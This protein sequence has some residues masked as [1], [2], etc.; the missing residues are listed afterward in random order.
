MSS[1]DPWISKSKDVSNE[2]NRSSFTDTPKT[3]PEPA[4]APRSCKLD[5]YFGEMYNS[6][7]PPQ[8][9][10]PLMSTFNFQQKIGNTLQ[11]TFPNMPILLI[12]QVVHHLL[13]N[14]D[15]CKCLQTNLGLNKGVSR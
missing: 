8:Q 13:G 9:Q 5:C 12:L 14:H 2:V 3:F 6:F 4:D 1:R 10:P 11:S 7:I 15:S